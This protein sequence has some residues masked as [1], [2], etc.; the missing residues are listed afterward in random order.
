MNLNIEMDVN[1]NLIVW[2][3]A[4]T[5]PVLMYEFII[6]DIYFYMFCQRIIGVCS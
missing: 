5:I 4:T 1:C 3:Y 2:K 6:E